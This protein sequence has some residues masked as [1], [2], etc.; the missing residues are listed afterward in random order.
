[1]T[2]ARKAKRRVVAMMALRERRHVWNTEVLPA[3]WTHAGLDC[4]M[5]RAQ[6][7]GHLCGYVRIPEGHPLFGVDYGAPVPDALQDIAKAAQDGPIGKRGIIEVFCLALG[8]DFHTGTI[9]NVH[10]GVTYS[11]QDGD[12]LPPGFWYGFDCGHTRDLSPYVWERYPDFRRGDEVY[13]D[14]AYVRAECES[15]AEQL[16][17][18]MRLC[19]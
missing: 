13:R 10:G 18:M 15:L 3:P 16:A 1:M 19:E 4:A 6:E 2:S 11:R 12:H 5:V 8:G 17:D 9:F 14:V 7:I